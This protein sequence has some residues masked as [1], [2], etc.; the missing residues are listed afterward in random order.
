MILAGI[1]GYRSS[2]TLLSVIVIQPD[3]S[4]WIVSFSPSWG[5]DFFNPLLSDYSDRVVFL[6]TQNPSVKETLKFLGE[7]NNWVLNIL[8]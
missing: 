1:W 3:I 7:T 5:D 2:Y 4:E 8:S 6:N